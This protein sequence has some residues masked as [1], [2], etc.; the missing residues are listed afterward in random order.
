MHFHRLAP[1][2]EGEN[3]AHGALGSRGPVDRH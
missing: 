3:M 1:F 2:H